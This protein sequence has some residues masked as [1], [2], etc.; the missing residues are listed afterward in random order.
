MA[1]PLNWIRRLN[2]NIVVLLCILP[3]LAPFT[4]PHLFEK[5]TMLVQGNLVRP[6]DWFDLALHGLPWVLALT[7]LLIIL[8]EKK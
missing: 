3:G 8:A 5:I 2:W 6:L 1:S 7:K 4:P